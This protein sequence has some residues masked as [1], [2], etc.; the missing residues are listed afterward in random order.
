MKI[1]TPITTFRHSTIHEAE[2]TT[3]HSQKSLCLGA[4][5]P[6]Q[7]AAHPRIAVE[8]SRFGFPNMQ[9]KLIVLKAGKRIHAKLITHAAE[10]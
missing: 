6:R 2:G 1:P 7:Q 8:V 3:Q 5:M 4:A 10:V 9:R